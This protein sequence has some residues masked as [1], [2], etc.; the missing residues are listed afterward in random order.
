MTATTWETVTSLQLSLTVCVWERDSGVTN[1]GH[2]YKWCWCL[3]LIKQLRS[4]WP[5]KRKAERGRLEIR[6]NKQS[7]PNQKHFNMP[8][9]RK[10]RRRGNAT[11]PNWTFARHDGDVFRSV[12]ASM[13]LPVDSELHL[14][15]IWHFFLWQTRAGWKFQGFLTSTNINIWIRCRFFKN[16]RM[17]WSRVEL[18]CFLF[19]LESPQ[20][21]NACCISFCEE[22]RLMKFTS[23]H[24]KYRPILV[25]NDQHDS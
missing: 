22:W 24:Y 13:F 2:M 10:R 18:L 8:T 19:F 3:R 9:N 1:A 7:H 20:G 5:S 4:H 14:W 21:K 23:L 17:H 6:N 11:G 16:L 25:N 12:F 15:I